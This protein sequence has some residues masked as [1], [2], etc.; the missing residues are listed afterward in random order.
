[1]SKSKKP[2]K[3]T[4][5]KSTATIDPRLPK[6]GTVHKRTYRDVEY[7]WR[8][9]DKTG[10]IRMSGG[11]LKRG[12]ETFSSIS[13]A[14]EHLTVM[15]KAKGKRCGY[16]FFG[17]GA[18]AGG[19]MAKAEAKAAG[20]KPAKSAKPAKKAKAKAT[21]KPAKAKAKRAKATK[22]NPSIEVS[23]TKTNSAATAA[24]SE[25]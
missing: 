4:A 15:A 21:K 6:I 25:V 17:L 11:K 19:V 22:R 7:T 14:A 5:S 13:A 1:M 16:A 8:V 20:K 23:S 9:A 2:A 18:K 24:A 12:G 10:A 3:S